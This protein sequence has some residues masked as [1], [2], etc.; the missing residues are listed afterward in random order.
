MENGKWCSARKAVFFPIL[1]HPVSIRVLTRGGRVPASNQSALA[2][3]AA[4]PRQQQREKEK[5]RQGN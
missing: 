3:A 5:E 1:H 2:A 4:G